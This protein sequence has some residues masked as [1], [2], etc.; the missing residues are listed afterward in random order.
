MLGTWDPGVVQGE[1]EV[2]CI[3]VIL[4]ASCLPWSHRPLHHVCCLCNVSCLRTKGTGL[5]NQ[6]S[7]HYLCL[8]G[9][10]RILIPCHSCNS[11]NKTQRQVL[12][13][14]LQAEDER[15][16]AAKPLDL[17]SASGWKGCSGLSVAADLFP[18][19]ILCVFLFYLSNPGI[20]G[21]WSQMLG[22][23]L[24]ELFFF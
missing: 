15:G 20:K 13:F 2:E 19:E 12:G 22:S 9:S 10:N 7:N 24:C 16:N 1:E 17:T 23:P 21:V 6:K 4:S 3:G 8:F 11:S 18:H 14:S 5:R